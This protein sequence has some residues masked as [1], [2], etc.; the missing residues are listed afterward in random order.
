MIGFGVVIA[1]CET[2]GNFSGEEVTLADALMPV[3]ILVIWPL[4]VIMALGTSMVIYRKR[5]L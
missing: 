3:A 4:A 2:M 5:R 1:A